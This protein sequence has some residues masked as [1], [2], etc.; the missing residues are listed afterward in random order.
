MAATVKLKDVVDELEMVSDEST[1]YLNKRTGELYTLTL[2]ELSAAEEDEEDDDPDDD[3]EWLREATVKAKEVTGSDEWLEL[4]SKFDI[5][6]YNIMEEFCRSVED[7]EI[8][9]RLLRQIRGSGAF[10]RF[11]DALD[12]LD[13]KEAWY[14]FRNDALE[15]IAVD[16]LE[17]NQIAYS[18]DSSYE[19]SIN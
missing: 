19:E 5:H 16:W 15:R 1:A 11:R 4:P 12:L 18:R 17:E 3:P 13:I 14:D 6:E 2:D 8:S 7:P 9:E 10:R